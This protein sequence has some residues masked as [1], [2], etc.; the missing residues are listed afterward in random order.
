MAPVLLLS[1][2]G[3]VEEYNEGDAGGKAGSCEDYAC[4]EDHCHGAQRAGEA[5]QPVVVTEPWPAL[6]DLTYLYHLK[7]GAEESSRH[8]HA[9]L[10]AA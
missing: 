9:R 1:R 4:Q 8:I 6:H 7:L 5:G 10:T 2:R 3:V